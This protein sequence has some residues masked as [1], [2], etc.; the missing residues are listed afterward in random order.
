M[1]GRG[2]RSNSDLILGLPGET[3]DSHLN[4]LH[5]LVD[6]RIEQMHNLQLIPLKGSE[7][8][9]LETRRKFGFKTRFRLGPKNYGIYDGKLVFDVEEVVVATDTLFFE[10]YITS[11]KYHLVSSVFWNDSWFEDGFQLMDQFGVKRSL[12]FDAML[13]GMENDWGPVKEF[14][15]SFV[16]ETENELFPTREALM[17][18]YEKEEN[19]Q[20]LL[21]G[22]IGDNLMYKYRARACF[23]LWLEICQIA[24]E[25]F[26]RLLVESGAASQIPDFE[27]FWTDFHRYIQHKHAHGRS[28]REI[29]APIVTEFQYDI[30]A[31]IQDGYPRN[32]APYRL[33]APEFFEFCLSEHGERELRSVLK[34]WTM[35]LSGLTKL[36][37]RI[38]AAW[39]VRECA[40]LTEPV[41]L[42]ASA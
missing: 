41:L 19:F 15:D 42:R 37:T 1:R 31:W 17:E 9:S 8:E 34:V 36:V 29:T 3:L 21:K 25:Q 7:L 24:M 10:D 26:K 27:C 33:S 23:F 38:L 14:L 11:R 35:E 2:L 12:A 39:Q 30:P 16:R 32:P 13:I 18:F 20:K 6:S 5:K 28:V 40:R 22:Q 4:A